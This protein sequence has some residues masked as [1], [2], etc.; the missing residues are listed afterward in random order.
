MPPEPSHLL[1]SR[2]LRLWHA[3]CSQPATPDPPYSRPP[4]ELTRGRT[5]HPDHGL[6]SPQGGSQRRKSGLRTLPLRAAQYRCALPWASSPGI[7]PASACPRFSCIWLATHRRPRPPPPPPIHRRDRRRNRRRKRRHNHRRSRPPQPPA[8]HAAVTDKTL[9]TCPPP[10]PPPT[11][12]SRLPVPHARHIHRHR[13]RITNPPAAHAPPHTPP[14]T[15]PHMPPHDVHRTYTLHVRCSPRR[16]IRR[17]DPLHTRRLTRPTR[18]RPD[19]TQ[20]THLNIDMYKVVLR[21]PAPFIIECMPG[22]PIKYIKKELEF[23][24]PVGKI[25]EKKKS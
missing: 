5:P 22:F 18:T 16:R 10:H 2:P 4:P 15:P 12:S 21:A 8:A 3:T 23:N 6:S 19:P 25:F 13:R 9:A 1:T 7:P 17:R 11:T 14:H 20:Q 24:L